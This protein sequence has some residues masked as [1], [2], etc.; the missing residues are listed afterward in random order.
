[1]ASIKKKKKDM[2][3]QNI[4]CSVVYESLPV[5]AIGDCNISRTFASQLLDIH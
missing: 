1:M 4:E 5:L 2:C 3:L